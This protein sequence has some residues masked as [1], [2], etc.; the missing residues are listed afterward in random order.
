MAKDRL[1]GKKTLKVGGFLDEFEKDDVKKKIDIVTLFDHFGIRLTKK[2][3]NYVALCPWHPDTNPSLSVTK[4]TGQYHCFS[5]HEAGDH[6]TLV[7]KM[8]GCGFKEAL[9]Y[10]KGLAGKAAAVPERNLLMREALPDQK[11]TRPQ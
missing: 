5:C 11:K 4:E 8:K 2:G 9:A 10:L 1:G 6:F 7:E 3:K